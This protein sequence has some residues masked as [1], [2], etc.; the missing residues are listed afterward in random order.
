VS[1]GDAPQF[2][3]AAG[4]PV[5]RLDASG[6]E[7]RWSAADTPWDLQGPTPPLV[8]AL[9]EGLVRPPARTLVVGCGAGHDARAFAAAGFDVTGV[10][11]APLAV[12]RAREIAAREGSSARFEQADVFALPEHLCGADLIF[13][14]TL[15][16]AIDPAQRDAYV[17]AAADALRP[18][19]LL[20]ALFWLIRT[21]TGPP[22][23]S[24]E[25]EVRQRFGRRFRFLHAERPADSAP[26]RPHEMLALLART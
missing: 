25:E 12:E 2:P 21:E 5:R 26:Q 7:E 1:D 22:F 16:C 18:G 11:F 13:D 20:L 8:R 3:D 23:G 4:R 17:D 19:G 6:W 14:H 9:R 15:F 24:T 10:D